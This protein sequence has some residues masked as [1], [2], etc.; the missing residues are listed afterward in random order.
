MTS[1]E[2]KIGKFN[3]ESV[4]PFVGRFEKLEAKIEDVERRLQESTSTNDRMLHGM[5][6][7]EV[8]GG[9][10][11]LIDR[12]KTEINDVMAN[13]QTQSE[14]HLHSE[15]V[16]RF[17]SLSQ[18]LVKRQDDA[19]QRDE[20]RQ[21]YILDTPLKPLLNIMEICRRGVGR[22]QTQPTRHYGFGVRTIVGKIWDCH[23]PRCRTIKAT[24]DGIAHHTGAQPFR[25]PAVIRRS[26]ARL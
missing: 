18:F 9:W 2:S 17:E 7:L 12:F 19:E 22:G 15:I 25:Q 11:G 10:N 23:S 6:E 4:H 13:T 16:Q 21:N 3:E 5:G 20:A 8:M 1:L 14:T 26:R 24:L